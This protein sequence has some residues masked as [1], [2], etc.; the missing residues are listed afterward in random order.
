MSSTTPSYAYPFDPTGTLASNLIQGESITISPPSWSD[1]YFV[2]PAFAPYF[3]TSLQ[4]IHH[5]SGKILS[6][7]VDYNC[8]HRFH[9]A[10]LAC[11]KPIYGSITLLDKTLTGVLELKYQTLGG[12]WTVSNATILAILSDT[13][14]NPRITTWEQVVDLPFEFPVI[15][16]QWDL[17]DLVGASEVVS[18]LE[19]IKAAILASGNGGLADHLADF[20][21][22]HR[23]TAAQVGLGL[24]QNYGIADLPTATAGTDNQSYMTPLRTAQAVNV[25]AVTPLNNHLSNFANPHQVT[26]AQVNLGNVQNYG[27]AAQADA[28]T[29]TS[30]VLYMTPLRVAQA[31]TQ[32]AVTP[33]NAHIART[34]NPHQTTAAQVGLG[35]VQNY[36]IAALADAQA[37]TRNDL[38]MTP[39]MVRQAIAA[40]SGGDLVNHINDHNNPH[41]VTAAQVGLSAVQNYGIAATADATAG[42]SDILYMTPLKVSQAITALVGTALTNHLN[43][44]SNPHMVTATQVGLGNVQN[45][46]VATSAQATAGT[47]DLA[48]MTPLKVAEAIGA[49]ATGGSASA[50]L[51][52][53]IA[54]HNNPHAVTAAQV[55][56]YTTAQSDSALATGLAGKLDKTA[57]AAD[58]ALLSGLTPLQ[59]ANLSKIRYEIGAV[60]PPGDGTLTGRTWSWLA[61]WTP[62][63]TPDSNNLP[64]DIIFYYIGGDPHNYKS[65]SV[66]RIR[67]SM[68]DPTIFDATCIHGDP[69]S[70]IFGY[71]IDA[72]TF[73]VKIWAKSQAKRNAVTLLVESDPGGAF[74]DGA[75]VVEAEP[76]G[77]VYTTMLDDRSRQ[78]YAAGPG[79]VVF[80]YLPSQTGADEP[81]QSVEFINVA[82]SP[83][84]VTACQAVTGSMQAAYR[85]FNPF[86]GYGSRNRN[87]VVADLSGYTWNAAN[88]AVVRAA[89]TTS[90]AGL[91]AHGGGMT[92]YQFEVEL[93]STDA[94]AEAIGVCAARVR[95]N[96]KD[97]GI[98]VLRTPGKLVNDSAG[99]TLPGGDIYRLLSVG[100]NLLQNDAYDL[101]GTNTGLN[102]GDGVVDSSRGTAGAYNP[103]GHGWSV[104]GACRV[105]VTRTGNSILVETTQLGDTNYAAGVSVTIDLTSRP[106]LSIFQGPTSWGLVS[107]SQ[108]ASSFKVLNRP[109]FYHPYVALT[110]DGNGEDTSTINRYTGTAWVA[111][112]MTI[113]QSFVRPGRIIYS[114]YN[115]KLF[116][117]RPDGSIKPLP[118]EADTTNNYTV[119]TT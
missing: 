104:A 53:H 66:Y 11:G 82:L 45:L 59:V 32:F 78:T 98:Y 3:Q 117:G 96:G 99:G 60:V 80:G 115:G 14:L 68:Q 31:I 33:L 8:T 65:E 55:G 50:D 94:G 27:I 58:S 74:G 28:T 95:H 30:N 39:A 15:D 90:L 12:A 89:A 9:D 6:E 110:F 23:V 72:L 43:D 4:V 93:S 83:S 34:D 101:G 97:F 36:G 17:V 20:N 18:A 84:D 67:Q 113:G 26:A 16:H 24:V 47:S 71:T 57:Q 1:F 64:K 92:S 76:T 105:R 75:L 118:I 77:I 22:P 49:L 88:S 52:A 40:Q 85:H 70:T 38:Y 107:Y 19:D 91:A 61:G 2:I 13:Q 63:S 81:G 29:G 10:S 86:S 109:D 44:T 100:V 87:A 103:S 79:E 21:N 37:G 35:L 112:S 7:G 114:D 54:D 5:P 41:Q 119:L 108:A 48:Y 51:A 102:W 116:F 62:P 69:T 42:T 106:E 25:Q 46:P 111:Q 73:E 56:A